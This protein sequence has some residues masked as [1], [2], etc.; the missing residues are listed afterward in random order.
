MA[1]FVLKRLV[2]AVAVLA[3]L[4]IASFCFF[5]SQPGT[6][7]SG[8][9]V[10]RE[11]WTWLTGV[12]S[13]R[14]L[15]LL[16]QPVPARL[17]LQ[18]ATMLDALGHTATLLGAA[19][20]LVLLLSV[21]FALA[22][23]MKRG[24]AIDVLLRGA[25]YLAWAVPAFALGLIVQKALNGVGGSHGVG[26]FPLAGWP[27]SCPAGLGLNYANHGS[28]QPCPA[29]GTGLHYLLNLLRYIALPATV[30]AVGFVGL[31]GRY[32]R[33]S[34]LETLD[35]PFV[36][37][38]RAKGLSERGVVVRHAM[39][40]SAPTFVSAVLADFGAI[41]GAAM[42][43][44]WIFEL[45][46]LGTVLVS[47]FPISS[48]AP[49]NIYSVQLVLLLTGALVIASSLVSEFVVSWLDPRMRAGGP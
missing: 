4:S 18:P 31:H 48:F 1:G 21:V 45:N 37:T 49:I 36:T 39:R 35:A 10:L 33:S 13:G 32:L 23:A 44:D 3:T 47:E 24:S 19:F 41:F 16:T 11:Y 5:A 25:S 29:A 26:P 12:G 7:P 40:A 30:L 43:V 28:I 22:T 34:L 6:I 17:N 14:S 15:R 46:G 27:G 20:L 42:A 38:A 2:A 8:Q 9:P